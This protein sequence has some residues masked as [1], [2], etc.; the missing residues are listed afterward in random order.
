MELQ[1]L[2]KKINLRNRNIAPTGLRA[3]KKLVAAT[4]RHG[5]DFGY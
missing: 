1:G 5:R 2:M 3:E 4:T